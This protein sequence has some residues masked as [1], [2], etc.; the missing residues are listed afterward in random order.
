[1]NLLTQDQVY[2]LARSMGMTIDNAR[3]ASAIA[4]C[5]APYTQN[6]TPHAD[7]DA[8]GDQALAN[9]TWGYSYGGFQIRSLRADKG[10]GNLRDETSLLDPQRNVYVARKIKL[11]AGS[12]MP[13]S[14]YASG[15]YKAYLQD[16]F[17]PPPNA[18]IVLAGDTLSKIAVRFGNQWTWQDLARANGL[19][20]PFTIF[21]G[22]TLILPSDTVGA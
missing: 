6:N 11:A 18:Y 10:T 8:I 5:E 17:P 15:M 19:H 3:I 7:F 14:T 21:I 1:V 2:D 20:D 9:A 12:F 22:Q 13:W 4:M 16:I